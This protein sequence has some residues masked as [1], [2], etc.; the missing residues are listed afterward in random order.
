MEHGLTFLRTQVSAVAAHH[1]T[2]LRSLADHE[3]EGDDPRFVNLCARYLPIMR[4][5][6]H[7]LDEYARELGADE[8]LGQRVLSTVSGLVRDLAD[9]VRETDYQ[10]LV[11]DIILARQL[12]DAFKT[13]REVGRSIG[14][15]KLSQ[16]GE[17][18]ERH[19]DD[20]GRDANRLVQQMFIE[21]VKGSS[22]D[23]HRESMQVADRPIR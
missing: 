19:H 1:Q 12:E 23:A 2:F 20:Y 14:M 13:F 5:H 3:A 17:M 6:Q 10:R 9:V 18:A 7:M 21:Q 16:I 22:G 11:H 15:T 4:D 8:S